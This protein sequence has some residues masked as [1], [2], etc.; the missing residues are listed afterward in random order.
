MVPIFPTPRRCGEGAL[1]ASAFRCFVRL[2]QT[3][4]NLFKLIWWRMDPVFYIPKIPWYEVLRRNKNKNWNGH[5]CRIANCIKLHFKLI[6]MLN[7]TS[8]KYCQIISGI[9]GWWV[10]SQTGMAKKV[11]PTL[12][13]EGW[14]ICWKLQLSNCLQGFG[15][16]MGCHSWSFL[17]P[18][19]VNKL[20]PVKFALM[21]FFPEGIMKNLTSTTSCE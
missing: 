5:A 2:L 8:K 9:K 11:N 15:L 18:Q 7:I 3:G 19:A 6:N 16:R 20:G 14:N 1:Q 4:D 13:P 10:Y 21:S 12:R 17:G